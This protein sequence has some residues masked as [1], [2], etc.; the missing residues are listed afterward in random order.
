MA[1]RKGITRRQFVASVLAGG[2]ALAGGCVAPT[3]PVGIPRGRRVWVMGDSHIGLNDGNSTG[4]E[5]GAHWLR[6]AVAD[7]GAPEHRPDYLVHVGDISH[8]AGKEEELKTYA[9]IRELADLGPWYEIVGNHDHGA[10]PAGRWERII[11]RPTQYTLIDGNTAWIMVSAEQGGSTGVWGPDTLGWLEARVAEN[12]A[13]NVIV[14]T[15]QPVSNTVFRSDEEERCLADREGIEKLLSDHRVDLWLCGHIHGGRRR[16]SYLM[17]RGR[18]AFVNVAS[19]SYAY[20]TGAATS[21]L[22]TAERDSRRLHIRT[23]DHG[24]REFMAGHEMTVDLPFAW[25]FDSAPVMAV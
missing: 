3:D 20:G 25:Q 9:R 4:G 22:L 24:R 19:V 13:R 16:R 8:H 1:L 17:R 2:V 6:L 15:H 21:C 12:Q 7:V 11:G 5:D 23:R 10:V 18:T 14:V